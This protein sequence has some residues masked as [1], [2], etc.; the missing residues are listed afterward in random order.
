MGLNTL[1]EIIDIPSLF[2]WKL[3]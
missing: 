3:E 1:P 2:I